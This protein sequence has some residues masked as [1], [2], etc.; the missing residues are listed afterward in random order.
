MILENQWRMREISLLQAI[1][2]IDLYLTKT[3][4]VKFSLQTFLLLTF[5]WREE[6][7]TAGKEEEDEEEKER[8]K[9]EKQI[10]QF[11]SKSTVNLY[12]TS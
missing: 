8:K 9:I 12:K 5:F 3:Q 2:H 1:I 6:G 4:K 7:R 10:D 11:L